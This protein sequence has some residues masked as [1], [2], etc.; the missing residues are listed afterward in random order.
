MCVYICGGVCLC[1]QS[2]CVYLLILKRKTDIAET[3][4]YKVICF[5]RQK[6]TVLKGNKNMVG[7]CFSFLYS[8]GQYKE[9]TVKLQVVH[10]KYFLKMG[11]NVKR[12]ENQN[13]FTVHIQIK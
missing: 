13:I 7:I 3:E 9:A 6:N 1:I 8:Q 4:N 10:R 5:C 2:E 12:L 11:Q